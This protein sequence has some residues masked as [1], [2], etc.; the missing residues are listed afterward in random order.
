[1]DQDKELYNRYQD[2]IPTYESFKAIT[3]KKLKILLF[4][5]W[6]AKFGAKAIRDA[7]GIN[8]STYGY[9]LSQFGPS[10]D[11]K[12]AEEKKT[13]RPKK[14]NIIDVTAYSLPGKNIV[15]GEF[16]EMPKPPAASTSLAVPDQAAVQAP[17]Q[18]K[19][20]FISVEWTNTPEVIQS[21]LEA[22]VA[23]LKFEKG[24]I[25]VK[26]DVFK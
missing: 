18:G 12:T 5:G 8:Y 9:C 2:S 6:V 10:A 7:M 26:L 21:Q 3:S 24:E 20:P 11:P 15:E 19:Q 1:M 25:T 4:T 22:L 23:V 14:Q 13:G 16:E 17:Q